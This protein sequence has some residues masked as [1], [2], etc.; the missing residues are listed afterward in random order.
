ME[1]DLNLV[2]ERGNKLFRSGNYEEA[3]EEYNKGCEMIKKHKNANKELLEQKCVFNSNKAACFLKLG[4]PKDGVACCNEAIFDNPLW[5]KSY[6]RRLECFKAIKETY[7]NDTTK[8]EANDDRKRAT[9]IVTTAPASY[10]K[11]AAHQKVVGDIKTALVN[12][13]NDEVIFIE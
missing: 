6:R 4:K 3:I 11:V 10:N 8:D 9:C 7:N 2:R 12:A 5:G 1:K 13:E